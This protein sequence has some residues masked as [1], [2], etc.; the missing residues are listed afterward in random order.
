VGTKARGAGTTGCSSFG[1]Y[2]ARANF[3]E[4]EWDNSK[5]MCVGIFYQGSYGAE[6]DFAYRIHLLR[7]PDHYLY[8]P[9]ALSPSSESF[10][11]ASKPD[12][13]FA[14]VDPAGNRIQGYYRASQS[15]YDDSHTF[16]YE[17]DAGWMP[18]L[19]GPYP[20]DADW[21][22]VTPHPVD[23]GPG[24]ERAFCY[25]LA[26]SGGS[27]IHV[28]DVDIDA[29][30]A[31]TIGDSSW[32]SGDAVID[33]EPYTWD[34]DDALATL[35]DAKQ[36][37]STSNLTGGLTTAWSVKYEHDFK[38]TCFSRHPYNPNFLIVGG[39]TAS[40]VPKIYVTEDGTTWTDLSNGLVG[41][42]REIAV[43]WGSPPT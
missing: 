28:L 37:W 34:V 13:W 29:S 30:S 14:A 20:I 9:I 35:R 40:D 27:F 19:M 26:Y 32:P 22:V 5:D 41:I 39:Y 8:C 31:A 18:A 24:S 25:G 38:P 23:S 2:T 1:G 42:P 6:A 4:F 16:V 33:C 12:C 10:D 21:R 11:D 43:D 15:A 3:E 36:T 17:Q 7:S